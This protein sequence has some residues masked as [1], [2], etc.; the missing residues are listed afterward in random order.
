MCVPMVFTDTNV[1]FLILF[2]T[3]IMLN[4]IVFPLKNSGKTGLKTNKV[5]FYNKIC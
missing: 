2:L 4:V 3:Y 5:I 1:L